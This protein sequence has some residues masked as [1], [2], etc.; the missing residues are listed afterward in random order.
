MWFLCTVLVGAL[1]H[2]RA[3]N[4]MRKESYPALE[5]GNGRIEEKVGDQD[6]VFTFDP[7]E[8][9]S[10]SVEDG[11]EHLRIGGAKGIEVLM[12]SSA[13]SSAAQKPATA[14]P[15]K[16]AKAVPQKQAKKFEHDEDEDDSWFET[17]ASPTMEN[18][19]DMEEHEVGTA[20][21]DDDDHMDP[22]R[23]SAESDDESMA[24]AMPHPRPFP[25][26]YHP[27]PARPVHEDVDIAKKWAPDAAIEA[28]NKLTWQNFRQAPIFPRAFEAL[29]PS[30][31]R[32]PLPDFRDLMPG[33]AKAVQ[34]MQSFVEGRAEE[35]KERIHAD[36]FEVIG[37]AE[38]DDSKD[39]D[40]DAQDDDS[41]DTTPA[42]GAS[43]LDKDSAAEDSSDDSE[44]QSDDSSGDSDA[45][46]DDATDDDNS[47]GA[48]DD[49]SDDS[50]S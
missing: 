8:E 40:D 37:N 15:Q 18:D 48:S 24:S 33:T 16:Q 30:F 35:T 34:T 50:D 26:A 20:Q 23:Q 47:D 45:Q 29:Q 2:E 11:K 38:D 7:H 9:V 3:H 6:L 4:A 49:S 43:L 42:A 10:L 31:H 12:G 32:R 25:A 13:P 39:S 21:P 27:W 44:S 41:D 17:T 28:R 5:I 14:L 1:H 46:S 36:G 22:D 19:E